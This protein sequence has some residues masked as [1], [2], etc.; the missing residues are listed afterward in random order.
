MAVASAAWQVIGIRVL[1]RVG[2]GLRSPGR[3]ALIADATPQVIHGRAFGLHRTADHLGAVLGSLM[4]FALLRRGVPVRQVLG[5]SIIPGVAALGV[6]TLVLWRAR[7][8]FGAESSPPPAADE[9]ATVSKS[10]LVGLALL[11]A[12]RLPET[13]ILLRIQDLGLP[14]AGVPLVWAVLHIV[15]SAAS[16]PSGWLADR[17]GIGPSLVLGTVAYAATAFGLSRDLP[18][19]W[20]VAGFLFHG[21]AGGFLEPAER[22]AVARVAPSRRGR[23]FGTYQ[24]MVGVGSLTFGL[25]YGWLYQTFSGGLA[26]LVAAG[27][28]VSALGAGRSALGWGRKG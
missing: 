19:R 22:A 28:A 17:A 26:L 2:K 20:A 1:D 11:A 24:A 4:A 12:V 27:M 25:G 21:L 14:V 3:D 5:A 7:T 10:A 15:K 8:R 23:A 6:L 13:L 16:Y 18:P 9:A